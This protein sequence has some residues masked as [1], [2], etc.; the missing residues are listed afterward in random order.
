MYKR[1]ASPKPSL[2]GQY[3]K[4]EDGETVLTFYVSEERLH[5]VYIVDSEY[6]QAGPS[7]YVVKADI[8]WA[9]G[10]VTRDADY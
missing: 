1:V 8:P 7:E 5:V 6:M 10:V 9:I 4:R 3:F 2:R